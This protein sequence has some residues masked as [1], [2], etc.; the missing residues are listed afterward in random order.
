MKLTLN[1]QRALENTAAMGI[2]AQVT[3]RQIADSSWGVH[4]YLCGASAR[5]ALMALSR[6]GLV[7]C[8]P[9]S[10][11]RYRITPAGRNALDKERG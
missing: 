8:I 10:P 9:T 4:P 7:E 6:K 1:Q 3:S 11:I 2:G 5:T